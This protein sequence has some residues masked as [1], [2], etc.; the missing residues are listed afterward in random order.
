MGQHNKAVT[1]Y[2]LSFDGQKGTIK[3]ATKTKS[4]ILT[5]ARS[6]D[7]STFDDST[8][9][10]CRDVECISNLAGAAQTAFQSCVFQGVP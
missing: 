3:T 9:N 4:C 7:R 6:F 2:T 10:M 5:G 8:G 1:S